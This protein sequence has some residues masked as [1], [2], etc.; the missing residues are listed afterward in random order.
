MMQNK[1]GNCQ[2]C[3]QHRIVRGYVA[4]CSTC[5]LPAPLSEPVTPLESAP[6][7]V[8]VDSCKPV[9]SQQAQQSQQVEEPRLSTP[10]HRARKR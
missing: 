5:G 1:L 9:A 6:I 2:Q 7:G 8:A 10:V 3:G 4:V